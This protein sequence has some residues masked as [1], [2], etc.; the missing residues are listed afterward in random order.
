MR[1]SVR[2]QRKRIESK[3]EKM[4]HYVVF[5]VSCSLI[6]ILSLIIRQSQKCVTPSAL[7]S[8]TKSKSTNP[9]LSQ[10]I[11]FKPQDI[12]GKRKQLKRRDNGTI[13]KLY[14]SC[15]TKCMHK[16]LYNRCINYRHCS[17]NAFR[18]IQLFS[19]C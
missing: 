9:N 3:S 13:N 11:H 10:I 12:L 4:I 17:I 19:Y 7:L 5:I 8:D 2:E 6:I 16:Y 14:K 15:R 1:K 18:T